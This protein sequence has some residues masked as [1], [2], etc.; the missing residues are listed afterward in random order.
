MK[1]FCSDVLPVFVNALIQMGYVTAELECDYIWGLLHSSLLTGETGYQLTTF[2]SAVLVLKNLHKLPVDY[3]GV[4]VSVYYD[5]VKVCVDYDDVK[6][7]VDYDDVMV[8]VD[9]DGVKVCIDF[10]GV[11]VNVDY[12]GFKVCIDYNGVEV[13]VDYKGVKVSVVLIER[14]M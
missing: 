13:C 10:D 3:D 11:E 14:D 6:V 7:C 1:Y 5:S 12:D 9:Y 8:C 4:K 2:S